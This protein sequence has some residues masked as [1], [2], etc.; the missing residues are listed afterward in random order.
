MPQPKT[1]ALGLSC[2]IATT[3]SATVTGQRTMDFAKCKTYAT[4]VIEGLSGKPAVF[5]EETADRLVASFAKADGSKS[6]RIT[7]T[8]ADKKMV[9]EE[10]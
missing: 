3:A 9:M 8:K 1:L 4:T 10:L 2:L 7:C 5:D 6:Y